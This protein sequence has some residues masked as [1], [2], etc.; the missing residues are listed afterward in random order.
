MLF[1]PDGEGK[2]DE[3]VFFWM[4][5]M[6]LLGAPYF[7]TI[8]KHASRMMVSKAFTSLRKVGFFAL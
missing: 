8:V 7:A 1:F 2:L 3:F 4:T 5:L 6:R